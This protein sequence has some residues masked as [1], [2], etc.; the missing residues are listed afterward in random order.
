MFT[1]QRTTRIAIC[2]SAAVLTACAKKDNAAIDTTASSSA[3]TTTATTMAPA[4]A[5]AP[6]NLADFAGKWDV[7]SVPVSGDTTPTNYVLTA[8]STT[9]GWSIKF[10]GRAAIP[11]K[12]TVAG[13]S[14]EIDAGPYQSVR[15]KGVTVT[16]NGG[17]RVQNGSLVGSTTAHY[18]VKTADSV[19][20]L[21]STG[22]RAK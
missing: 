6:V 17:L 7:R 22:T 9:S 10:P 8:T 15:R 13:D 4:P 19:L 16:T 11:A 14:V 3:S 5:P 18:K 1:L 12:V 20:V 2:C 21:N